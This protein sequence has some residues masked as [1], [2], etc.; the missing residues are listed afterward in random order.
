MSDED[1][2]VIKLIRAAFHGVRLGKGVGLMQGEGL[3]DYAN[4]ETLAKYR[5]KDEKE[6]WAKIPANE[7]N[8]YCSSLSFF[9]SEGMRFHLPAFMIA[10]IE[11]TFLQDILFHLTYFENEALSRFSLL[12]KPQRLAVREYLLLRLG[13]ASADEIGFI[14]PMIEEALA[15]YWTD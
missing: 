3:D 7:L 2:R 14:Q 8:R 9:D 11:G 15:E 10:D 5:A 4:E 12:S 1:N 6:D 13:R